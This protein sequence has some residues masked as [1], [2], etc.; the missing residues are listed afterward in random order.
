MTTRGRIGCAL[1]VVLAAAGVAPAGPP[2]QPPPAKEWKNGKWQVKVEPTDE[3]RKAYWFAAGMSLVIGAGL[4]AIV[5]GRL[6]GRGGRGG[7][8][9]TG[10]GLVVGAAV[11][12]VLG[13]PLGTPEAVGPVM[14]LGYGLFGA[15]AGWRAGRGRAAEVLEP[16]CPPA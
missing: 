3:G 15:V 13:R 1:A 2:A 7:L 11:V 10:I 5:T 4:G 16:T 14:V 9:G 8:A 12:A 6:L